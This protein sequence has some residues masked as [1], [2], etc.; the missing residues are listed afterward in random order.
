[1]SV[2]DPMAQYGLIE[3]VCKIIQNDANIM[4][5]VTNSRKCQKVS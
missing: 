5:Q 3:L 1:M 2:Y 4:T